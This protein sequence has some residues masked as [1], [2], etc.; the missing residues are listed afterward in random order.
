MFTR[1]LNNRDE[2]I[3]IGDLGAALLEHLH[4]HVAGGFALIVHIR[5]VSEPEHEH[6]AAVDGLL[7]G[8]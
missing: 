7:P 2:G 1:G 3:V 6:R 4:Q 5:L 8:V